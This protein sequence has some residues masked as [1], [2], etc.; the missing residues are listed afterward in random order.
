MEKA[1]SDFESLRAKE[2]RDK[3]EELKTKYGFREPDRGDLDNDEIEWRSGKPDYTLANY[4]FLTGKTQNHAKDG[5]LDFEE[6][7]KLFLNAF[8]KGFPWELLKVLSK[9]P[10][11]LLTWRHWG[12]FAGEFRRNKGK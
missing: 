4:A 7:H 6:S 8:P 12:E 5:E 1:G 3:L 10:Y 2:M 11:V 9:P